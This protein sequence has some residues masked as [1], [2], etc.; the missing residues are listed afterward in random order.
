MIIS[1]FT[2][3]IVQMVVIDVYNCRFHKIFDTRENISLIM[4]RDDI[5]WSVV[6][7]IRTVL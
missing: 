5:Y 3:F 4:D 2:E 6:I 7:Y 1:N